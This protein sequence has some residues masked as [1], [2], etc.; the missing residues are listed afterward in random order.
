MRSVLA[1]SVLACAFAL[2]A[3]AR[4]QSPMPKW[5]ELPVGRMTTPPEKRLAWVGPHESV[6][7]L[8]VVPA[9]PTQKHAQAEQPVQVTADPLVRE[10]L[11]KGTGWGG[12]SSGTC[13]VQS[14]VR[15]PDE[16][17]EW[18]EDLVQ[19]DVVYRRNVRGIGA[20]VVAVHT[21][22]V[23]GRQD[24]AV[25]ESV[26]AW[27][28]PDTRGV[29]R[30][31]KSSL[32]LKLAYTAFGVEVY[33][34]RDERQDGKRFVQF[35]VVQDDRAPEHDAQLRAA[36]SGGSSS[37]S[38]GCTHLRVGLPVDANGESALIVAN[39]GL[40]PRV[41]EIP[42]A[43]E[44]TKEERF[45]EMFIQ[46]STSQTASEKEPVLSVSAGWGRREQA[47]RPLRE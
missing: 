5:S 32:P 36:R 25:L 27:V 19:L 7:G 41:G 10:A 31:G 11:M 20:G 1:L 30:I 9:T 35:V 16:S 42:P 2:V 21:E 43:D 3:D 40:P 24:H 26:D 44:T 15:S 39:V 37:S 23:V 18:S 29:R 38:S 33:A 4:A 22:R 46:V 17:S 34:A 47:M 6:P 13:V 14:R 8:F 12:V 28:D 45:R